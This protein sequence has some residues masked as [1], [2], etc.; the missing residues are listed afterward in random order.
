MDSLLRLLMGPWTTQ[1]LWVLSSQGP[2]RFGVLKREVTG[3]S[4]KVLTDRLRMLEAASVIY[5]DYKPTV[6]PAVTYGLTTRGEELH[7]V[8]DTL[9]EISLRWDKE[10]QAARADEDAASP[11]AAA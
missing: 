5:R 1:I 6:P 4:S 10:E 9:N 11:S 2:L 8:L 3:V 7:Q